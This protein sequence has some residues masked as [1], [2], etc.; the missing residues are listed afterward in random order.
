[1]QS[2]CWTLMQA[3]W[4]WYSALQ[5]NERCIIAYA[6]CVLTKPERQYCTTRR[7]MLALVRG[8][9]NISNLTCGADPLLSVLITV[10]FRG[11]GAL[12]I[13]RDR[14]LHVGGWKSSLSMTLRCNIVLVS[15]MAMLIPCQHFH[16]SSPSCQRC[17][18]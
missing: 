12:R 15:N 4:N 11:D 3:G 2:S 16:V 13:H 17:P 5:H 18:K 7:E 6:S 1:M 14:L 10:H 9:Y 8:W